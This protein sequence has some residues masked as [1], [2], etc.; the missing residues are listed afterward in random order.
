MLKD[1]AVSGCLA[2]ARGL[3][4]LVGVSQG[5]TRSMGEIRRTLWAGQ[6]IAVDLENAKVKKR[7]II[8]N[9]HRARAYSRSLIPSDL[10]NLFDWGEGFR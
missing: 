5:R 4:A 1:Q 9:L 10:Y 8:T 2:G 7:V 6:I 3:V